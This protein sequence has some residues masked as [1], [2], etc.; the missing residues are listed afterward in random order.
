M[1]GALGH[2]G[3]GRIPI[4]AVTPGKGSEVGGHV[5]GEIRS[6]RQ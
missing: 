5:G 4:N 3:P 2:A 1:K 6:C